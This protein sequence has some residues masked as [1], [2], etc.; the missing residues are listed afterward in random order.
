MVAISGNCVAPKPQT[1]APG[2]DGGR[3]GQSTGA[4][5]IVPLDRCRVKFDTICPDGREGLSRYVAGEGG[6]V[7]GGICHCDWLCAVAYVAM[8]LAGFAWH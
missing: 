5:G 2:P 3:P 6:C 4:D 8:S 7:R 1:G